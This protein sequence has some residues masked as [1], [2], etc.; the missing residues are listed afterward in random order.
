[1]EAALAQM[2]GQL[3]SVS[4][5]HCSKGNGPWDS[6]VVADQFLNGSCGNCHYGSEGARC[7]LRKFLFPVRKVYIDLYIGPQATATSVAAAVAAAAAVDPAA[8]APAP[9]APAPAAAPRLRPRRIQP[10]RV[11]PVRAAPAAA[12]AA[13]KSLLLYVTDS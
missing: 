7:S 9:A 1:M 10:V 2:T 3:Q 8:S 13:R 6:C 11:G 12:A 4:C 5:A